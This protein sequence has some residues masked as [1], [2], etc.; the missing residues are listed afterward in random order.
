MEKYIA[1]LALIY[2]SSNNSKYAT[3]MM[4]MIA[5]FKKLWK[6]NLNQ[7]WLDYSLINLCGNVDKF[8]TNNCFGKK[9]ILLNSEKICLSTNITSD[10]F[11]R[12]IVVI[13]V[14]SL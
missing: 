2:Q 9:I 13:Y 14:I 8:M 10:E 4:H 11:L 5:C 7:T 1:Y 3:K 12:E 6:T